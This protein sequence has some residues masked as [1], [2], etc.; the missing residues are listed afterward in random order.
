[1]V[2]GVFAA[3]LAGDRFAGHEVSFIVGLGATGTVAALLYFTI[4]LGKLT[5]TT[6]NAYGSVMSVATIINGLR[7]QAG[8]LGPH[9]PVLRYR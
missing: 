2:F 6:L 8:D 1:M 9:A 5:I 3:A 4:A 7:R